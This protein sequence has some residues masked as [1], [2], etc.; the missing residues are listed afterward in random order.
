M[1][2]KDT[3][4]VNENDSSDTV[5]ADGNLEFVREQ[6][7]N[8]SLPSYQEASGAP[9]EKQSPLGYQVHTFTLIFLNIGQMVGTGVFSTPASILGNL[10]SVGL[11]MIYWFLGFIFAGSA[12]AIYLELSSYFPSRSGGEVVYLEQAYPRPK[13]LLPTAFAVQSVI[14]SFSSSNAIVLAQYI[15][16]IADHTPTDWQM[17]GVAVAGYSIAVLLLVFSNKLGLWLSNAVGVV[18]VLTLL[19]IS[20]TGLVVL[21]GHTSV[22]DP[23]AN[24]RGS[25][26]GT[27]GDAY[28][29]T[30]AL[31]KVTFAYKGYQNAFNVV[32]E[33]PIR[34]LT[35]SAPISLV[36]VAILYILCNIAYFAAVPKEELVEAEQVAASLFFRAVFGSGGASR[37]L[38]F[39]IALS[40]FGNLVT[41]LIGQSRAIRECG[42]QGVIPFPKFWAST[43]PFGTPLGPYF[44]KWSMTVLMI[45][46]PPAG[47]AFNFV[48]DLQSYP[49]AIFYFAMTVGLILIRRQRKHIGASK[50]EFRSWDIALAITLLVNAFML[51]MPWYPPEGGMFAGDVSFWYATYVVVGI[52]IILVCVIY[53]YLWIHLI[54]KWKGYQIRQDVLVLDDGAT[55]HRLV[56]VPNDQLAAWDKEHDVVGRLRH[57]NGHAFSGDEGVR[58]GEP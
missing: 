41:V 33:N 46:A 8:D 31:V 5:I 16:R 4:T 51:V 14:V 50:T 12:L 22:S 56:K 1:G 32:N 9:V 15:F 52:A 6:G 18:K 2:S 7:G 38:N 13:Y 47:D 30:N 39:L 40:A 26:E 25:F 27:S 35:R 29:I 28:G 42:R 17:K 36:I 21:G 3:F 10:G 24:F 43:Y 48:V 54:P 34:T 11:S 45:L 58:A 19:F 53:Y 49:D 20:I 57:R 44:L 55:T 23:R 37:G